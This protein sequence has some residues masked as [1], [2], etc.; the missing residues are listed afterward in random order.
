M[1]ASLDLC[2]SLATRERSTTTL[3]DPAFVPAQAVAND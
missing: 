2:R 1:F 3:F